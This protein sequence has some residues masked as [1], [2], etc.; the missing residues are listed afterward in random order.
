MCFNL[1]QDSAIS[2]PGLPSIV[3]EPETGVDEEETIAV[4]KFAEDFVPEEGYT[5]VTMDGE[6][7]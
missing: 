7:N 3:H 4:C 6:K 1:N 2:L 5:E